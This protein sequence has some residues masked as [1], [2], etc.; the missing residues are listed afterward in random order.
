MLMKTN[1]FD[2]DAGIH[3]EQPY[4]SSLLTRAVLRFERYMDYRRERR[5]LLSLDDHLLKDIGL[6]RAEA[7]R[8]AR[9]PFKWL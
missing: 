7:E 8:I 4:R 2:A 9:K 1:Q 6:G 5:D 3:I